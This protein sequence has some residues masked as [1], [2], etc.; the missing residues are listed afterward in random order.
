[1]RYSLELTPLNTQ[2]QLSKQ[3]AYL[4]YEEGLYT[5]EHIGGQ[6]TELLCSKRY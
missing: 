6:L 2:N 5:T 1:M 4:L 3:P